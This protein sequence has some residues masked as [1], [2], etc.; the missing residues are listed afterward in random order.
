MAQSAI[1][2]LSTVLDASEA[3][4]K[5]ALLAGRF[6]DYRPVLGG[7]I[8]GTLREMVK[9]QFATEGDAFGS[10][11]PELAPSTIR[12]REGKGYGGAHPIMIREGRLLKSLTVRGAE[13]SI[14]TTD[15]FSLLFGTRVAYADF[16][17][18]TTG[19]GKGIIPE[20]QLIPDPLPPVVLED[21]RQSIR[22]YLIEGR[23]RQVA[24]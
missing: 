22:D 17:Q 10:G 19:P 15:R 24:T 2:G 14:Y 13:G 3:Q 21:I 9:I 8:L 1:A 16:H 20:R 23:I 4:V 11:W 12:D 18:Q 5:F 6:E 7:P